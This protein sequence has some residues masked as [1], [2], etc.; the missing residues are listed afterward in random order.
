FLPTSLLLSLSDLL[1]SFP[2]AATGKR[3]S[4][5]RREAGALPESVGS[6]GSG[7]RIVM[8]PIDVSD[9]ATGV[10]LPA[11]RLDAESIMPFNAYFLQINVLAN[12]LKMGLFARLQVAL[13]VSSS[14]SCIK[15]ASSSPLVL[16][17][18]IIHCYRDYLCNNCK[19]PGHF[20]R[21][22]PNVAV[23]NN[24][25]L[26]G[27][28]AAECTAKTLCWN[29][30][31]PGHVASECSNQPVCH[32]CNKT[33]HLARDCTGSG[34]APFDVRLC[35]NC[36]KPGH[37]AAECTNDKACNNCRKTGHLARDC[38]ND[39]VCNLC[40]VSGHVARNCPKA[41]LTSEVHG[42]PLRDI[43]CRM[44]GQP[45]HIGRDC[46]GIVICGN[47]GGRGHVAFECPS[48]RI[49]DRGFRRF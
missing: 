7:H 34:L 28:I 6:A 10:W 27:H 26:P 29:C 12:I 8:P 2:S 4:E 3:S 13:L 41:S 24:C 47:C 20:A 25:S 32:T 46:V 21:D 18:H 42:G 23:C 1:P 30:K 5:A 11:R 31:E 17:I 39:P 22:C 40:N 16:C 43:I 48:G 14:C 36:H 49:F 35:N 33:G 37:I 45:G 38:P 9:A 15:L 19:R 44:C